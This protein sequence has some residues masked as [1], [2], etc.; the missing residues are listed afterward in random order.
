MRKFS[1]IGIFFALIM[2]LSV[3]A[4]Y[5]CHPGCPGCEE[6]PTNPPAGGDAAN[7][8]NASGSHGGVMGAIGRHADAVRV[9][10]KATTQQH[11]KQNDNGPGMTCF[12]RAMAMTQQ[13]GQMF[14]DVAPTNASSRN[15]TV[16]GPS[17]FPDMGITNWLAGGLN[18]VVMPVVREH[19]TNFT[20][21]LSAALG[22]TELY[23]MLDDIQ[24]QLNGFIAGLVGPINDINTA[25]GTFN[26]YYNTINTLLTA[27]GAV[28]PQAVVGIVATIN[29]VWNTVQ[30]F[31]N[32]IISTI[33]TAI[34]TVFST[35]TGFF[36]S[37]ISNI[38]SQFNLD[39]PCA[40]IAQLW[41]NGFPGVPFRSLIGTAVE[42]G[43]PY[44]S[45]FQMLNNNIPQNMGQAG[46][47]LMREIGLGNNADIIDRA[48][49]DLVPGGMLAGPGSPEMPSWPA[50][51]VFNPSSDW[52]GGWANVTSQMLP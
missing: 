36:S 14:S 47:D 5:S 46:S 2:G 13:L 34:S 17:S 35:I 41:G 33:M 42:R 50:V 52:A 21:S 25:M 19:A 10:E 37:L 12:D 38:M 9:R 18:D 7:P 4:A 48:L 44:F 45:I 30:T 24:N 1:F 3:T 6:T 15:D 11:I 51:P 40:R 27:L 32:T 20:E 49:A 26:T 22:A 31:I 29:S 16:F 39:G 8:P 28:I 23:A 43:T